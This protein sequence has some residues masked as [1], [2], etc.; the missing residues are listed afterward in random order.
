MK[1]YSLLQRSLHWIMALII[2]SLIILGLIM[3][4]FNDSIKPT[5]Y[6]Y[7]KSFGALILFLFIIRF[8][9]KLKKGEP[10]SPKSIKK[11]D[12]KLGHITHYCLY[13]FMF[14]M[15]ASG[16]VMSNA[17]GYPVKL[18]FIPLPN[19]VEKSKAL[20]G[21]AHEIHEISAFILIALISLHVIG[22]LKHLIVEKENLLKRIL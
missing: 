18:F 11:I 20:S 5:A 7:H 4:D 19:L 6:F 16:W 3:G 8:I 9:T 2:I 15:P 13:F 10:E 12:I 14:L 21:I 1:K 17:A 22:F